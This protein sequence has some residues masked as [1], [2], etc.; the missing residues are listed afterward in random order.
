M[1]A[2]AF[3][4]FLLLF[5]VCGSSLQVSKPCIV[6]AALAVFKKIQQ[7]SHACVQHHQALRNFA[8]LVAHDHYARDNGDDGSREHDDFEPGLD[9]HAF[10]FASLKAC[11]K[12]TRAT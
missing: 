6:L 10:A 3:P 4:F 12:S 9:V 2:I 1:S 7:L 5:Q 11:F 8:Q